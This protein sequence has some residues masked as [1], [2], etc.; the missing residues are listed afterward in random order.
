MKTKTLYSWVPRYVM[1]TSQIHVRGV[2]LAAT[3]VSLIPET[4]EYTYR[5]ENGVHIWEPKIDTTKARSAK[6]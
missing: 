4:Y 3:S 5:Y 6:G 2:S 1:Q